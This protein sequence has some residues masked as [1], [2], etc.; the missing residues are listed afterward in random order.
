MQLHLDCNVI[1]VKKHL[2]LKEVQYVYMTSHSLTCLI[3]A[4]NCIVNN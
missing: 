2:N 1:V 4:L 3:P